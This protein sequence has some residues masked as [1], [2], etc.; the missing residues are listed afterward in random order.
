[1]EQAD[2]SV[3]QVDSPKEYRH[4]FSTVMNGLLERGFSALGMWETGLG[5]VEA[6]PGSWD[7]FQSIAPQY[8]TVW[9]R[10]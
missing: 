5:D 10:I 9:C 8:I 6:E 7:H 4:A 1:V 2:G 3:K